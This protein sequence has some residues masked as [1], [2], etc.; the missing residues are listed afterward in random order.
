[1]SWTSSKELL[2]KDPYLR[3]GLSRMFG[4]I[5]KF[6]F[7]LEWP[8]E[9]HPMV[10]HQRCRQKQPRSP[11]YAVKAYQQMSHGG[12]PVKPL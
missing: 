2:D 1:M 9:Q 6:L 12:A 4:S 5:E 8:G 10:L 11:R 7:R 3:M